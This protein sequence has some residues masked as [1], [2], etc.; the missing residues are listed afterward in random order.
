MTDHMPTMTEQ[1]RA[2]ANHK[3]AVRRIA[4]IMADEIAQLR[5]YATS[6]VFADGRITLDSM[7]WESRDRLLEIAERIMGVAQR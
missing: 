1:E 7:D 2:D 6:G 5:P 3:A 4:T